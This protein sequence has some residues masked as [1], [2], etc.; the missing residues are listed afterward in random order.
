MHKLVKLLRVVEIVLLD[1]TKLP[2]IFKQLAEVSMG[3]EDPSKRPTD[4]CMCIMCICVFNIH[5]YVYLVNGHACAPLHA[6]C[7]TTYV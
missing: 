7:M 4:L 2:L 5:T 3:K 6:A 1:D